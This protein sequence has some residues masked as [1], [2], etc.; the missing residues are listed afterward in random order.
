MW[1]GNDTQFRTLQI[2]TLEGNARTI[3]LNHASDA[4]YYVISGAGSIAD[5][6]SSEVSQ[7]A[8]GSMVHIDAGDAY[9][10]SANGDSGIKL[11]GGPCP[12]DPRLYAD[13]VF[14]EGK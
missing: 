11:V 6:K 7:L 10:F 8:E 13:L 4:V 2:L 5:L 14:S 3:P 12:A 9:Q 1:P